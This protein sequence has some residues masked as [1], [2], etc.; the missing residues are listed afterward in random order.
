MGRKGARSARILHTPLLTLERFCLVLLYQF[1]SKCTGSDL[2]GS[3][4]QHVRTSKS[5]CIRQTQRWKEARTRWT[6]RIP[7]AATTPKTS[8]LPCQQTLQW[9]CSALALGAPFVYFLRRVLTKNIPCLS[10]VC[11]FSHVQ[12]NR[13]KGGYVSCAIPF[14]HI[15]LYA[16]FEC[17]I[18]HAAFLSGHEGNQNKLLFCVAFFL[19]LFFLSKPP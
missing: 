7:A 14:S 18:S 5:N 12:K 3:K 11:C 16:L 13:K 10:T 4:T 19:V 8:T 15:C 9:N 1:K 2:F 6:V 17:Y